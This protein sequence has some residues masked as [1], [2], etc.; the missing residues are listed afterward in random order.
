MIKRSA[1][2]TNQSIHGSTLQRRARLR[3]QRRSGPK[4]CT[5]QLWARPLTW[6]PRRQYIWCCVTMS[7]EVPIRPAKVILAH[8][9]VPVRPT[10]VIVELSLICKLSSVLV[11]AELLELRQA[12]HV[13]VP[14]RP[15]DFL[16]VWSM[17]PSCTGFQLYGVCRVAERRVLMS[18]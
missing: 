12:V 14:I 2:V 1:S 16:V 7:A 5:T 13:D 17:D 3:V 11:L 18:P 8:V 9:N 4:R 15:T 10:K 6:A